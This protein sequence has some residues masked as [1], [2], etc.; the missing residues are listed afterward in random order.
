MFKALYTWSMLC[1][2][3]IVFNDSWH[4]SEKVHPFLA[5]TIYWLCIVWC[6]IHFLFNVVDILLPTCTRGSATAVYNL[7]MCKVVLLELIS[8]YECVWTPNQIRNRLTSTVN[9]LSIVVSRFFFQSSQSLWSS[10]VY[11]CYE[12]KT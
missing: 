10:Y 11:L 2:V 5:Y 12:Y 7:Q 9:L 8:N 6:R 1:W 4:T 3:W